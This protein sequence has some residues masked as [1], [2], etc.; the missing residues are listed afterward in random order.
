M[1]RVADY[2]IQR[3][4]EAGVK[5]IFM[6]T[7]RGV[8]YLS[9]AV[10]REENMIG[11]SMHHEQAAAFAAV[12]Y[13][14]YNEKIGA[15]LVSTGC[16]ST[17]AITG[18]L[19]AWQDSVPCVFISGQNMLKE[20][21]R[22]SGVKIRT[23]GQQEADIVEVVKS[24]TKYANMIMDADQIAYEMDKALYYANEGRKGPVWLD[25]PLDI[26]NMR[27]D[28]EKLARYSALDSK[29]GP[30]R[31]DIDK[32]ILELEK[33]AR[34]VLVIGSGIRAA[35]AT[36]ILREF[37][38]VN[39]MPVVF[40]SAAT[41]IYGLSNELSIGVIGNPG[42]T[43]AANFTVQ[44]ADVIVVVGC[45]MSP[46]M[47]GPQYQKFGRM[48]KIIVIDIDREEHTKGTIRIDYF[49]RSDAK[50]FFEKI[51][52]RQLPGEKR[53]WIEKAKHW[54]KIFPKCEEKY[55]ISEKVDLYY[56]AEILS[57]NM[58]QNGVV[59]CDAG[60]EELI[61]PSV[62]E[63]GYQQRCI[64]PASQGAM[65]FALPAAIGSYYSSQKQ[66]VAVIGDG[67]VMMNLQELQTISYYQIPI[68]I[69]ITNNNCYSV[70]R[71]RQRELFRNR[72]IGTDGSNGVSCPEFRKVAEAFGIPFMRIET[73]DELEKGIE[74]F[75]QLK[76]PIIC[77]VMCVEEQEYICN[78]YVR[79]REK[80]FV[81]RPI[82]DQAPF[83]DREL[84]ER[85]MIIPPIDL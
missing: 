16:A 21:T 55:K 75:M 13:A 58:D 60:I 36:T 1:I 51:L 50:L 33:A 79:T 74:T 73:T 71:K 81:Q 8:L 23:F 46:M 44:N 85:E 39:P 52:E 20:T 5:H 9:D 14:E 47:T 65:G 68:K 2:I 56:L 37:L 22:Y 11:V 29:L 80:K 25:V 32:V 38:E 7:G 59:L 69:I 40:D 67:S 10:A 72:T 35:K 84:F 19:C 62:M 27:V 57:Q 63:F 53:E 64:H 6:V 18:L 76:G 54:K 49:I 34:P 30:Q 31:K 43:R 41:D 83:I 12:A 28:E 4:N 70:I 45:R 42:G 82:E 78:G 66:T 24:L 26:Q 3:L 48:A 15:C 17:N 77:E 61:F